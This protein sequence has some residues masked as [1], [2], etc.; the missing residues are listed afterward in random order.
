MDNQR[1][2]IIIKEIHLWKKT[3]LLPEH[4]CNY[5]LALYSE[6]EIIESKDLDDNKEK[7]EINLT[8][9]VLLISNLFVVPA[10]F[11]IYD[12][13][14]FTL[15]L[16]IFYWS[17]VILIIW[18]FYSIQTKKA[19]IKSHYPLIILLINI[20]IVSVFLSQ[21]LMNTPIVSLSVVFIQLLGWAIL[22]FKMKTKDKRLGR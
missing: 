14:H 21:L 6:G 13:F 20:L 1:K 19:T 7:P 5:L 17:S 3:G 9:V 11:V 12:L 4:Y 15:L 10:A 22:G 18:S 16:Q 2:S 8:H